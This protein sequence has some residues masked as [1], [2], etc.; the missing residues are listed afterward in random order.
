MFSTRFST[1]D[2]YPWMFIKKLREL[3]V[4]ISELLISRG[5]VIRYYYITILY[6]RVL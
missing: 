4:C 2:S 5:T 1:A 6:P 3:D